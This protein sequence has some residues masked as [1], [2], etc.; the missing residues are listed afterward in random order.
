MGAKDDVDVKAR[1]GDFVFDSK[2][3]ELRK[4]DALVDLQPKVLNFLGV[5]LENEG[6]TVAQRE[7]LD[8]IWPGVVV[9]LDSLTRVASLARR[10]LDDGAE[11][12]L[13]ETRRG[14][15]YRIGI[16]IEILDADKEEA[17][18][19]VPARGERVGPGAIAVLP[20]EDLG[21]DDHDAYFADG[22]SEDLIVRLSRTRTLPVIDRAS[23]FSF[24]GKDVDLDEVGR[25][26]GVRYVVLGSVRRS[27]DRVRVN[28]QLVDVDT[29]LDLWADR[30][31]SELVEIFDAQ[32]DLSQ[33][34][35]S[36]L[37][38]NLDRAEQHRAMARRGNDL[39]AWDTM[40]KGN[41]HLSSYTREGIA[42]GL[43]L[44]R[45]ATELD[46]G[47]VDA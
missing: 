25:A 13:L 42:E 31:D 43:A 21:P 35:V 16:P 19:E 45:H 32:D 47:L 18:T 38:P 17:R 10:A 15:G 34:I 36:A 9:G 26:L 33:A 41:W 20:F 11:K 39:G 27:S 12:R 14:V 2:A 37:L 30:Y 8:R 28:A 4:G 5:L 6:R 7:L 23:S 24:R 22:L 46:P 44:L 29:R 3:L 40:L 1:F